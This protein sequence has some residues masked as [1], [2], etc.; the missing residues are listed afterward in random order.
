MTVRK[1]VES[2]R[3]SIGFTV[4]KMHEIFHIMAL[5]LPVNSNSSITDSCAASNIFAYTALS[6]TENAKWILFQMEK[7]YSFVQFSS[8]ISNKRI[9]A[10][11]FL[12]K[13][14]DLL[15]VVYD[16]DQSVQIATIFTCELPNMMHFIESQCY[17]N[18]LL[19]WSFDGMMSILKK[20]SFE[21]IKTYHAH[22]KY[23]RGVKK[24]IC[25]SLLK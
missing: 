17:D 1:C 14:I 8:T 24:G 10:T 3:P 22:N 20:D 9:I 7:N 25:D 13:S 6:E 12:S 5:F 11:Q 19:V 23:T 16:S 4:C 15:E 2:E 18:W 21:I